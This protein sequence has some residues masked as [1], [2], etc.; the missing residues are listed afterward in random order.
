MTREPPMLM[1]SVWRMPVHVGLSGAYRRRTAWADAEREARR[2]CDLAAI[3]GECT[4]LALGWTSLAEVAFAQDMHDRASHA[5]DCAIAAVTN[6]DAP[7][8]AWRVHAC[9]ARIGAAQGRPQALDHH[10]RAASII[11]QLADSMDPASDLR[12]AFLNGRDV[13]AALAS[14]II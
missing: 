8:A 9:A 3:S 5:L 13:R 7:V 6:V 2:A 12:R 4:W 10:S 1:G 11:G 14:P